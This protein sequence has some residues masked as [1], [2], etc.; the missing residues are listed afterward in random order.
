MKT[1][2][3]QKKKKKLQPP[4]HFRQVRVEI[5][6]RLSWLNDSLLEFVLGYNTSI[7]FSQPH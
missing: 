1:E 6:S 3:T 5:T 2:L 7:I 4:A